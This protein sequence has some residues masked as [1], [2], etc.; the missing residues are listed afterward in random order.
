MC[1][2]GARAGSASWTCS[3]MQLLAEAQNEKCSHHRLGSSVAGDIGVA[4]ERARGGGAGGDARGSVR[5][6]GWPAG[7]GSAGA[8]A[9]IKRWGAK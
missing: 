5:P 3:Q 7:M 6:R 9:A 4:L 2:I 8:C 1:C